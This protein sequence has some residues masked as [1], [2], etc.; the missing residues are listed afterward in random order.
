MVR[1]LAVW[2]SSA[3]IFMGDGLAVKV[4]AIQETSP[5][6]AS[7]RRISWAPLCFIGSILYAAKPHVSIDALV[8]RP[9]VGHSESLVTRLARRVVAGGLCHKAVFSLSRGNVMLS[10]ILG[11]QRVGFVHR[12]WIFSACLCCFS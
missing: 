3:T 6:L 8:S 7:R 12:V 10:S 4:V 1:A 11:L 5:P 2:A 9:R